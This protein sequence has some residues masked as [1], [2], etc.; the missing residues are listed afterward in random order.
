MYTFSV[1]RSKTEET[2]NRAQDNE[3][4]SGAYQAELQGSKTY[5]V[6]MQKTSHPILSIL[7]LFSCWGEFCCSWQRSMV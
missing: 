7:W 6:D 1:C 5:T 2:K 4:V 3:T